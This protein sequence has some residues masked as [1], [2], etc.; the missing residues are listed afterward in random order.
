MF[1]AYTWPRYQLSV[2]TTIGPLVSFYRGSL[3]IHPSLYHF[4]SPPQFPFL[5]YLE[6]ANYELPLYEDLPVM[7]DFP[8]KPNSTSG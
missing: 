8:F 5:Y 2:Y 4:L 7:G 6:G 1:C 3:K